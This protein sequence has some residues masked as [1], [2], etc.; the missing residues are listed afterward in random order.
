[1]GAASESVEGIRQDAQKTHRGAKTGK[2][3][4]RKKLVEVKLDIQ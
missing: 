3:S 2:S 4:I 1:M